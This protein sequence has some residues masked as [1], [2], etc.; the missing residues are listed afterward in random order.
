VAEPYGNDILYLADMYILIILGRWLN[1]LT[2]TTLTW[3]LYFSLPKLYADNQKAIDD[4]LLPVK[5]KLDELLG[6][7][8]T[9]MPAAFGQ[10]QDAKKKE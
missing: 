2:L 1:G 7:V 5:Q 8:K 4:I 9:S 6:K 3:L 10:Q